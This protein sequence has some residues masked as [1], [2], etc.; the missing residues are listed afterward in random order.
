MKLAAVVSAGLF[1]FIQFVT[2]QPNLILG[3]V[4]FIPGDPVVR[5]VFAAACGL[6]VYFGVD[7]VRFWPQPK[8]EE[9]KE[10]GQ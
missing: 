6:A 3:I 1:A 8:I 9:K 7:A 2:T 4:A 10:Q 5:F